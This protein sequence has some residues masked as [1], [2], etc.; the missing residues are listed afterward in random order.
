MEP[1]VVPIFRAAAATGWR[2]VTLHGADDELSRTLRDLRRDA[3]L[4]SAAAAKAAGIGQAALSRYETGRFVPTPSRLD[5]LLAVYRA[6]VAVRARLRRIVGDLR[7]E[8]RRVVVHRRAAPAF[9][10]RIRDI[11]AASSE[12]ATFQ[13]TVV[14][15]LLQTPAYLRTL[16]ADVEPAI[17]EG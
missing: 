9:Q 14:P 12:I 5:D 3:G 10:R 4:T 2:L 1:A 8:N 7:A 13:P 6:P 16:A 11:E 15:G 17:A